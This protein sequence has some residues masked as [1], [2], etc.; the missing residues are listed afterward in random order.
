MAT[1]MCATPAP[2]GL[3]PG[4]VPAPAGPLVAPV[5][6][7]FSPLGEAS[8]PVEKVLG[9]VKALVGAFPLVAYVVNGGLTLSLAAEAH[10]NKLAAEG[11]AVGARRLQFFRGSR[12]G[13][14]VR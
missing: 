6:V 14:P 3:F 7:L 5:H 12:R 9:A 4:P 11:V 8:P 2:A 1:A 10:A 13:A